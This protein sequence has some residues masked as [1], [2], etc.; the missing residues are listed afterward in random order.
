MPRDWHAK[1]CNVIARPIVRPHAFVSGWSSVFYARGVRNRKLGLWHYAA[2]IATD[3]KR[4][5][6]TQRDRSIAPEL[7][8]VSSYSSVCALFNF[9]FSSTHWD[10]ARISRFFL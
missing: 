10:R 9:F 4:N 2:F 5:F 6:V 3:I 1:I 7:R 8:N